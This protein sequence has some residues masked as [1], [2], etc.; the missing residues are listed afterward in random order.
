MII[1]NNMLYHISKIFV[2]EY[3]IPDHLLN[4]FAKGSE[5]TILDIGANIGGFAFWASTRWPGCK[6]HCYEPIPDNFAVLQQNVRSIY[7]YVELTQAAVA[8]FQGE[9]EMYLG[10]NNCGEASFFKRE[11]Q[12]DQKILV[13]TVKGLD[14][15]VADIIKIDTEGSEILIL[16]EITDGVIKGKKPPLAYLIEYHTRFAYNEIHLMLGNNHRII[17]NPENRRDQGILKC[18]RDADRNLNGSR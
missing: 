1:P 16:D 7:P 12:S 15:P 13:Q 3:D 6:I 9:R 14:L 17:E 4:P 8:G 18:I 10:R 2:G 5:V 11:E